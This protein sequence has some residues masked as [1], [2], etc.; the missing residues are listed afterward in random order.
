MVI[1][2]TWGIVMQVKAR[3]FSELMTALSLMMDLDENRKIY[4][5]WRVAILAEKMSQQILP[6]Y[7]TQIFYAGLLHD[8][9][10]I[11]LPDHVVH[12]TD[13]REHFTNP[14]LFNHSRKG[15][16]IARE[17]G[18]L[19][20]AAE[21]IM[22]H[23]EFWN[24]SG[25]PR[26]LKGNNINIG[27]QILRIAD[28]FDILARIRPPLDLHN[29]KN[30][31]D[32]RRGLEFS[33]LMY[34]LMIST[35]ECG[36]FFE[37]IIDDGKV[38]EMIPEIINSLPP[39]DLSSCSR[40]LRNVAKIFAQV[41]DAKHSYTAGHS[42]RVA[43]YTYKLTKALGL[44]D[45]VAEKFEIA[46]FLH[47]AGK[48][49]I[50][51]SILDKPAALTAEEFKLMKRHPVYTMEIMSMVSE[52]KDLVR[53]AGG[54]HERYD[55]RGY[56]DGTAGDNIPL[57]ARIMAVADAFDAMTSLRPYQ[58]TKSIE[59]AKEVLAKNSGTQFDPEIAKVAVRVL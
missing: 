2:S 38:S 21:M 36:D 50:P 41:I 44:S 17:I 9:G 32:S 33:D 46:A 35:L 27:G 39:V 14:I 52:L 25:Y 16:Q 26:G 54:H 59:E 5:A 48:V 53:I 56:P 11:S 57:G 4:H 13:I 19:A 15:A 37:D 24:G 55:G 58:K 8:I 49:A 43:S 47:D 22:D 1:I 31:L 12:Y 18:P 29:I 28:T 45:D 42:E 20:L 10:A 7:R 34:E 40:D 30:A 3:F 6:E 51:R 23:H